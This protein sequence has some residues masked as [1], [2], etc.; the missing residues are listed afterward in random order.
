MS[1]G[2]NQCLA[3]ISFHRS[4]ARPLSDKRALQYGCSTIWIWTIAPC[5]VIG[6]ALLCS[7]S[8]APPG[9]ALSRYRRVGLFVGS[10]TL[11]LPSIWTY[12]RSSISRLQFSHRL[13][14]FSHGETQAPRQTVVSVQALRSTRFVE[15][16]A[17]VRIPDLPIRPLYPTGD[18]SCSDRGGPSVSGRF[19]SAKSADCRSVS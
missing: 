15:V 13:V 10:A 9:L 3:R 18:R 4:H 19:L 7:M 12:W 5:T 14:I 6:R 16:I 1:N 11:W 17:H 8:G 2:P